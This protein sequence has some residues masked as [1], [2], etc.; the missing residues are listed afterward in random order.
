MRTLLVMVVVFASMTQAKVWTTVY[1]C[2]EKTPLAAVDPNHPTVYRDIMVGTRLVIVVS[3][4]SDGYWWGGLLF[5]EDEGESFSL[6]GRGYD[7]RRFGY[8]DSC[9]PAAGEDADVWPLVGF[10]GMDGFEFFTGTYPTP[11]EWFLFD[12]QAEQIGSCTLGFYDLDVSWD[13]PV[14]TLS[15]THVRSRDFDANGVVD[16]EDLAAMASQW[17]TPETPDPNSVDSPFDLDS[18]GAVDICDLVLFNQYWLEQTDC[19]EPADDPNHSS[20][21]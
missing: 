6:S 1:R 5:S 16:F 18:S 13:V 11:G 14:E 3:S 15:L 10:L 12:Y 9:L 20:A 21:P 19:N 17:R 4:D 2:D 7:P 8:A